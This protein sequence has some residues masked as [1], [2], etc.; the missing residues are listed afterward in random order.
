MDIKSCSNDDFSKDYCLFRK[1]KVTLWYYFNHIMVRTL[2]EKPVLTNVAK[3][4]MVILMEREIFVIFGRNRV[5]QNNI[6][7]IIGEIIL[8]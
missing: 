2:K 7:S 3:S 5:E 1:I 8:R 6:C 4:V